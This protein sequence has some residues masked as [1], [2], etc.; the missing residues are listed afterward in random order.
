VSLA[1]AGIEEGRS[2]PVR[3]SGLAASPNPFSSSTTVRCVSPLGSSAGFRLYDAAGNLVRTYAPGGSVVLNG[4]GLRPGVY[5]L[6]AGGASTR[7]V[8]VDN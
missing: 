2:L 6:R 7:L 1:T 3:T 5:L 4:A 8:K